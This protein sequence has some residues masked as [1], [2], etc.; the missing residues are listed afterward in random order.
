MKTNTKK[1]TL[2]DDVNG[3]DQ[4]PENLAKKAVGIAGKILKSK[5]FVAT[6]PSHILIL[7]A[8]FFYFIYSFPL[9]SLTT[10]VS[11]A[12]YYFVKRFFTKIKSK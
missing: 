9:M 11:I 12:G 1:S 10:Y 7:I 8:G 6:I 3:T 2:F 4:V 5:L